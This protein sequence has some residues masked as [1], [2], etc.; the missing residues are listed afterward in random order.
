[1]LRRGCR[2][3]AAPLR[4][5]ISRNFTRKSDRWTVSIASPG[6]RTPLVRILVLDDGLEETFLR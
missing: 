4:V 1:M 5:E 2:G 6:K 3:A